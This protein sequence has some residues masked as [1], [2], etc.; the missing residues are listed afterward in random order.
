MNHPL[1]D[2]AVHRHAGGAT[3]RTYKETATTARTVRM[4]AVMSFRTFKMRVRSD[5]A[6]PRRA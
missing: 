4:V 2:S 5:A 3:K 1:R 6:T